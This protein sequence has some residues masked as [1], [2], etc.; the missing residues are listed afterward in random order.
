M[1]AEFLNVMWNVKS[2]KI[3]VQVSLEPHKTIKIQ[4]ISAYDARTLIITIIINL[5]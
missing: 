2:M 4:K 3:R 5:T 1:E